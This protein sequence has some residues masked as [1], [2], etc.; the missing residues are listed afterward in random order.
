MPTQDQL[1]EMAIKGQQPNLFPSLILIVTTMT[2][3]FRAALF[4]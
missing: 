4:V 3:C 1:M 2:V